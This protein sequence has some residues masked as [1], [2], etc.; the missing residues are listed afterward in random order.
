MR[1]MIQHTIKPALIMRSAIAPMLIVSVF[2]VN[3]AISFV[4]ILKHK[5]VPTAIIATTRASAVLYIL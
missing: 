1:Q 3:N 2:I 5:I 4:G